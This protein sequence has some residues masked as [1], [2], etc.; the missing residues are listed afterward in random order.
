MPVSTVRVRPGG[1]TGFD[2]ATETAELL[3]DTIEDHIT[4]H[5]RSQ[6][7]RIGPS[8][9]GMDCTRRLI[10]KLAGD[11]EPDRGPAWKPTVGTACHSQM[12]E[13]FGK[14][15]EY[16]PGAYMI[17]QRVK[18]GRIGDTEITGSTD[19]FI[20]TMGTVVDWKFVGPTRLKQYRVKGPSNQYKVQAHLYGKGWVAAGYDVKRVMIAFLPR[21]GELS[22]SYFWW[23]DFDPMVG[24]VAL[25]KANQL[26]QEIQSHGKDFA[27]AQYAPCEDRWCPWCAPANK[28]QAT[29]AN[30]MFAA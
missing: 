6:Q 11:T 17:E 10:H 29:R 3:M 18:V 19:L 15:N 9:I 7:V 23:E 13:W 16:M 12:E 25:A 2:K 8:E 1:G 14:E 21:D 28:V 22:D 20:P 4:H 26:H 27:L 5:P 24:I 30:D